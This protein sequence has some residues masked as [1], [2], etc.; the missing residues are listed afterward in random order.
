MFDI[1]YKKNNNTSLFKYLEKHDFSNIQNYNP[2]YKDFFS[3]DQHNYNNINLNHRYSI[4]NI[5]KKINANEYN[6]KVMDDKTK[7]LQKF[8]SFFKFSPLMDPVKYMV[9]KYKHLEKDKLCCLP[10]VSLNNCTKKILDKNNSAY[11]DSFF[12][13]L[14]SK[15]LNNHN[16]THGFNFFGSFLAIQKEFNLN[17]CDDI[18]YLYDSD[19]FHKNNSILFEVDEIDEDKILY[20]DTRNYR[21]KIKFSSNNNLELECETIDNNLFEGLFQEL[22]L[23]NMDIH[24]N[25][26]KEEYNA[27][28]SKK[29][30]SAKKTNSTCSSRSSNTSKSCSE[31]SD[32]LSD[33]ISNSQIS[34]Y[35][36]MNSDDVINAKIKNFPIQIICLEKLENTLDSL[37][38]DEDNTITIKQW[39]SCLFQI[40]MILITYQKVFN[41]THNDLHTNNIMYVTTD[42]K[43]INYKFNNVYYR[44]PTYGKIF[45][46]I[47]FGRAIYSFNGHVMCSDS[48]HPKG[49]AATQYNFEPYFNEKKPRLE[50]NKSFD[51]C[52]LACSLFDYFIDDIA[53]QNKVKHPIAQL[54]IEWTK[55]DKGRNILYKNN[56]EERYPEFKLYKMIVR[57]VH[58]HLPQSQLKNTL[59]QEYISSKRKIKKQK[60]IN[61][62]NMNSMC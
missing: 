21:K 25:Q 49:D 57:T 10:N 35:S 20:S 52:R 48:Y 62:D 56:G 61:I 32:L 59:F 9:G 41:F 46:I 53:N 1:Y 28:S 42:K 37:I 45:K 50:A 27:V 7:T 3:L 39:K 23:Q 44:V 47:D 6:I 55:D 16:F 58:N 11:I 2:L 5:D 12:S 60:I 43:F 22:T 13:Y 29:T 15:L 8:S 18:D 36:S 24:N 14:S 38:D 40:I 4:K 34:D 54:I 51:L 33:S 17:I 31:N 19:F 26:L 30:K